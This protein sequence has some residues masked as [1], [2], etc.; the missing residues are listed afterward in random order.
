MKVYKIYTL[1]VI[2]LIFSV[3]AVEIKFPD[4]ELASETVL[5]VFDPP[6]MVL[7]RNISL[8]Y[9]FEA[10]GGGTFGLDE[11]FYFPSYA[12]G[13]VSFYLSEVHGLSL[14]ATWFPPY[15]SKASEALKR[16][17][18]ETPK[19]DSQDRILR[20]SSGRIV[21]LEYKLF[22]VHRLPYPQIMG[23]LNYQY[24]PYYGK[25][26]LT[27]KLV[28]NLSIYGFAGP[29]L[30]VFNEGT[31][32]PAFNMGIGQKIYLFRHFAFKTD[33]GFYGYYGPDPTKIEVFELVPE[34]NLEARRGQPSTLI[35]Y[36]TIPPKGKTLWI[37]LT[38]TVGVVILL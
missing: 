22:D 10:G 36:S 14:T 19:K 30:I 15:Y 3:E 34:Q 25:I 21:C 28:M 1:A 24:T 23:F 2:L 35:P 17:V 26:S 29:G 27:K 20:D 12:T 16:G 32:L 33:V 13:F 7:N 18:C 38:A 4:E 37:H 8:K 11:P 9:R 31:R 6:R 5:P